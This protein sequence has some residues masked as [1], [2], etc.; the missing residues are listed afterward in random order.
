MELELNQGLDGESTASAD[1]SN[2]FAVAVFSILVSLWIGRLT[3]WHPWGF[4]TQSNVFPF[5]D[6][7]GRI[8]NL[9]Q[10]FEFG[11][12]YKV[13]DY[14]AFTYPPS[15]IIF[16]Y[17]LHYLSIAATYWMWAL[18]SLVGL[19]IANLKFLKIS[20]QLQKKRSWITAILILG[21]G[22]IF[23]PAIY[24]CLD[25]G[26]TGLVLLG[27]TM[28]DFN[29]VGRGR[30]IATGLAAAIK[31]YPAYFMIPFLIKKD[32]RALANFAVTF[33]AVNL[34]SYA[35]WRPSFSYFVS[36]V[37]L[38]GKE[39]TQLTSGP[40]AHANSSLISILLIGPQRTFF[41]Q[42]RVLLVLLEIALALAFT[43]G[44]WRVGKQQRPISMAI[45]LGLGAAMVAPV[46]WDH[47]F[48]IAFFAP[49]VLTEISIKSW[50]G[51]VVALSSLGLYVPW[52]RMRYG[53]D[54]LPISR[55]IHTVGA[56]GTFFFCLLMALALMFSP[57]QKNFQSTTH[58]GIANVEVDSPS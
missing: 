42:H 15:A 39:L 23:F 11:N 24:E 44:V 41:L 4:A 22:V 26:Q 27:L 8:S 31:I 7:T 46:A 52:W 48:A 28:Y 12:I 10:L 6:L 30:G 17:P 53:K 21:L 36:K 34:V 9:N 35:L 47:Y 56:T 45:V 57:D 20:G 14:L 1:L 38:G 33:I 3:G 58:L 19:S 43:F 25:L 55:Y 40:K 54:T 32:W 51:R 2:L 5:V 13:F 16:F 37:V 18:A 29:S 49:L 50:P